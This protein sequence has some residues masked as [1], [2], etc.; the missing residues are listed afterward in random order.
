MQDASDEANEEEG[1]FPVAP[2]PGFIFIEP[3]YREMATRAWVADVVMGSG[4]VPLKPDTLSFCELMTQWLLNGTSKP[5]STK[6]RII[7]E[8]E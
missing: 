4:E 6:L 8:P 3:E 5:T 1:D 2:M 7:K